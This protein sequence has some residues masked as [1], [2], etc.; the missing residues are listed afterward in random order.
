MAFWGRLEIGLLL[1]SP[2]FR[3]AD[4]QS[5]GG[6]QP[7]LHLAVATPP[8]MLAPAW[9]RLFLCL[10]TLLRQRLQTSLNPALVTG[11]GV[12][13][14]DAPLG[15]AVD[16]R[17]RRRKRGLGGA[18]FLLFNQTAYGSD[19]VAQSRLAKTVD[20][21]LPLGLTHPF[22]GRNSICHSLCSSQDNA[23]DSKTQTWQNRTACSEIGQWGTARHGP[24]ALSKLEP[25]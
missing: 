19:L 23:V 7:A 14:D 24:D 16:K 13:L 17:K 4:F 11:C 22:Q 9:P 2:K 18:G 20:M 3:Q 12:L 8:R 6:Y 1:I 15:G 25:R 21:C 10:R 5:A